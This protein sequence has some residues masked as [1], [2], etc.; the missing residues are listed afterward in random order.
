[1]TCDA[2]R[3]AQ[4]MKAVEEQAHCSLPPMLDHYQYWI[5]P[6]E[7]ALLIV[8]FWVVYLIGLGMGRLRAKR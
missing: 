4:I 5:R 3:V 8:A 6:Y 7:P 2:D 1:M